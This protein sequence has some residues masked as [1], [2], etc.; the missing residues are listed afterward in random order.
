MN[1]QKRAL[2]A[3]TQKVLMKMRKRLKVN[4]MEASKEKLEIHSAR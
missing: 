4:K 2:P 3:Q 1:I